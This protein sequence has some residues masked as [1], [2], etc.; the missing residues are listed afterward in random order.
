MC[1]LVKKR[2][3]DRLREGTKQARARVLN[4]S[5]QAV[6]DIPHED[7][8]PPRQRYHHVRTGGCSVERIHGKRKHRNGR[9]RRHRR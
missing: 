6:A 4:C 9:N 8:A 2:I 7:D 1:P 5:T 3:H